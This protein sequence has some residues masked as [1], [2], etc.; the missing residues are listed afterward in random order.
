MGQIIAYLDTQV[1]VWTVSSL[2]HLLS[3][4]ARHTL[5]SSSL[6]ISP[7]VT[8]ELEYLH[9]IGRLHLGAADISGKLHREIGLEICQRPFPAVTSIA[10]AEKW[11]RDPFDRMI[12]A[13]AKSNGLAPLITADEKIRANYSNAIW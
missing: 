13:H 7:I 3:Q 4:K 11:T 10:L 1:V 6:L 12:V 9:E 5:N 2:H 8:L